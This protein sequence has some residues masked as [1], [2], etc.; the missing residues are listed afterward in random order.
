MLRRGYLWTGS[1]L[2]IL[3]GYLTGYT[4][5][6]SEYYTP[7]ELRL[8]RLFSYILASIGLIL[9]IYGVSA[10][11]PF[12]ILRT[13]EEV[14]NIVCD[15]K[16]DIG[17]CSVRII[18]EINDRLVKEVLKYY[19]NIRRYKYLGEA[20]GVHIFKRR[21]MGLKGL[22][23]KW[24]YL[25]IEFVSGIESVIRIYYEVSRF[26]NIFLKGNTL[27]C[28]IEAEILGMYR[29]IKSRWTKIYPEK[30]TI[31]PWLRSTSSS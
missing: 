2:L 23:S 27:Y 6:Y 24:V 18:G 19:T 7:S 17:D 29:Y 8:A 21:P 16:G 25:E 9:M 4:Y 26:L 30:Y 13:G 22:W 31:Y 20:E 28:Y 1:I 5:I 14:G 11:T 12:D 10:P 15:F 3:G